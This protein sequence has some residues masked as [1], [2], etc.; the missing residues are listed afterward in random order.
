[1]SYRNNFKFN[2]GKDL[3]GLINT[4]RGCDKGRD[5]D[6]YHPDRADL[7]TIG[8]EAMETD[9]DGE[10]DDRRGNEV[11]FTFIWIKADFRL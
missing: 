3:D 4:R 6:Y 5:C 2:A 9:R 8:E 7:S 11:V 10:E 1:M